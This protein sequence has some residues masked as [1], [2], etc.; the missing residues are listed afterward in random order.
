MHQ[1]RP[2]A[3]FV[4]VMA[5]AFV[6][7]GCQSE[8][9]QTAETPAATNEETEFDADL[10]GSVGDGPIM[11][12][13]LTVLSKTGEELG[14]TVSNHS[15]GYNIEFRTKGKHYPLSIEA[16]G[17]IDL[18][19]QLPP[20]FTLF[21]AATEPRRKSIVN[22][23][24]FT[25]LAVAT[26]RQMRGGQTTS[27]VAAA[28]D[29]VLAEFNSGL[30]SELSLDPMRTPIDDTNLAEI[31]K[32]SEALVE[33][34]RRVQ[35]SARVTMTGISVDAVIAAIGADLVDGA[36][37]GAG[38]SGTDRHI[39][40]IAILSGAQ[41]MV[42]AMTNELRV[43]DQVVTDTLDDVI[44]QLASDRAP[45]LTASRPVTSRMID[46]ARR[47]VDAA[48]AIADHA[49]LRSLG[50]TLTQMSAGLT[51][52]AAR[53][54]LPADATVT[55]EPAAAQ[56]SNGADADIEAALN[57]GAGGSDPPP[58]GDD[59][60]PD[61]PANT[62]PTISGT[63]STDALQD[64]AYSFVPTAS[65][66]DGDALTFTG[67]NIPGWADLNATTGELSGTPTAADVGTYSGIGIEVSDGAAT[68]ALGPF[69]VTVQAIALGSATVSWTAPT[70]NTDGTALTDLAGYKVYWGTSQ[71]N[72]S[73]S[74][75]IANPG[76]TSYLVDN[77]V[78]DTY[79]FVATAFD[80]DGNESAFSNAGSKVIP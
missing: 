77:L 46:Q 36:L 23:N 60:D 32:A 28:L 12:A 15:A 59:P 5:L 44:L 58:P 69:S 76:V 41:V 53:Q 56:L 55:L 3:R 9:E 52:E 65:D 43:Q 66:A 4:A 19:S 51:P 24:P 50:D 8:E 26:A 67:V 72:Y 17:G 10:S 39:S 79:Y 70:A 64:S 6:L 73:S 38:A 48:I 54:L 78:P 21:S 2:P 31:V 68:A 20:G 37:D 16:R 80:L 75:I 29:I 25:T 35:D 13:S 42:E 57:G 33:V 11:D 63:P 30:T 7:Q 1:G 74:V 34:F 14:N 47:G 49:D 61:P 71:G 45:D 40:A 22:V 18:V 62:P 27:N